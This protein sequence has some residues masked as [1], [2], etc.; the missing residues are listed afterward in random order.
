MSPIPTQADTGPPSTLE[1][2]VVEIRQ[3]I[4]RIAE[5]LAIIRDR[6]GGILELVENRVVVQVVE[7][8]RAGRG[9]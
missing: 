1:T 8:E 7:W 2:I 9:L 5:H 3:Q 4:H 6:L